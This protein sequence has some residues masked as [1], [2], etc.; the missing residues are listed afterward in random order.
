MSILSALV[1]PLIESHLAELEPIAA[2]YVM[3]NI[4]TLAT[5]ILNYLESKSNPAVPL[6]T[7]KAASG[8]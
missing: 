2:E 4:G 5:D 8:D 6:V 7:P 3:A 1:I